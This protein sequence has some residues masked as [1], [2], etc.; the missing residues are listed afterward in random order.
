MLSYLRTGP[1]FGII[2]VSL[3]SC[4][5]P[6]QTNPASLGGF[7]SEQAAINQVRLTHTNELAQ[8]SAASVRVGGTLLVVLPTPERIQ[9]AAAA[10]PLNAN[11]V[12]LKLLTDSFS[13]EIDEYAR[14]LERARV[15]D[16]V[17]ITRSATPEQ[18]APASYAYR[19]WVGQAQG[20][21]LKWYLSRGGSAPKLIDYPNFPPNTGPKGIQRLT[22]FNA[23]VTNAAAD[24]GAPVP[25]QKLPGV[26]P[27]SGT[28]FFIN[29][30]GAMLTNNHVVDGCLGLK[31]MLPNG[32][33]SD[34]T[35]TK[36]DSANDLA[37]ITVAGRSGPVAQFRTA[38]V[39]QGEDIIV[40]G[41]PLAG[42]LS[43]QGNITTGIVSALSGLKDDSRQVQISA[44]VQPGNSGGPVFD[45]SGNVVAIAT[46]KLNTLGIA[47]VTQDIAQNV[48]FAI[49]AE[50]AE[51]FLNSSG[52]AFSAS[53][54]KAPLHTEDISDRA[55]SFTNMI[56]CQ[57]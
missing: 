53:S 15:F 6:G 11:P 8:M 10:T 31:V 50:I 38:P 52:I 28:G 46:G 54:A 1:L 26:G 16:A 13:E 44:P 48:N 12:L 32:A 20:N 21:A 9:A 42:V 51:S 33:V 43:S 14:G 45:S 30:S 5:P 35:L 47:Q 3:G 18:V 37:V 23:L 24:L 17:T 27:S 2:A 55:R 40:Y 36:A 22:L 29:A 7:S 19:L 39:R 49:K 25:R 56:Q 34:A 41:F 4:A 57:H